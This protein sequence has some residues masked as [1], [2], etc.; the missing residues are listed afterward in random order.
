MLCRECGYQS[1]VRKGKLAEPCRPTKVRKYMIDR[2]DRRL[3]PI[4]KKPLS[5]QWKFRGGNSV[6]SHQP[7][8]ADVASQPNRPVCPH[9][10]NPLDCEDDPFGDWLGVDSDFDDFGDG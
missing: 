6:L 9:P 7:H 5:C 1:E 4:S 3:H 10:A 2:F 8:F